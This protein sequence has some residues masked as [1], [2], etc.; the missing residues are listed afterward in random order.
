[1]ARGRGLVNATIYNG[2]PNAM[3]LPRVS[4]KQTCGP[5]GYEISSANFSLPWKWVLIVAS[6]EV[7]L[8]IYRGAKLM[9]NL[10]VSEGEMEK[11]IG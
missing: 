5:D 2:V 7:P 1:M 3:R 9:I 8:H 6:V 10:V 11:I 4:R